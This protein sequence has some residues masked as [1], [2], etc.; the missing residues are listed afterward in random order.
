MKKLLFILIFILAIASISFGQSNPPLTI[1]EVD[2]SPKRTNAS[3]LIFPNGTVS[4]NGSRV[5]IDLSSLGGGTVTNT[6]SL[7]AGKV[8]IG[9]GLGDLKASKV[10]ITDPATTATLT[11][12][13]NKVFTVSNTLTLAGTDS[14]TLNVGAGGTLGTAAFTAATAYEVP[15][16][17]STGLGRS[18]NTITVNTTLNILKISG[19]TTNGFV[20]TSGGDGTLSV[21]TS[22]YITATSTDTL[23]NKT[24]AN[25]NNSL[26]SVTVDVTGT[27]ATGDIYYRNAGGVLTRLG[28]GS[29]GQVL[30]L[31]SGLPSWAA[32]GGG[33]GGT[34]AGSGSEIQFRSDASTFG[35]VT[36]SSV[37]GATMTLAGILT[38]GIADTGTNTVA[39]P[40]VI[41]HTSS[42]TTL[43][44]FGVGITY[45]LEG[46]G[47]DNLP[48]GSTAFVFSDPTDAS[49]DADFVIRAVANSVIAEK[50]RFTSA[51]VL[52]I[53]GTSPTITTLT[54]NASLT[55]DANG[56]GNVVI[57]GDR[58][59]FP[60]AGPGGSINSFGF[61]SN[62][63]S[64][65]WN[66]GGEMV[67]Y[68]GGEVGGIYSGGIEL[69]P[70][71]V[72]AWNDSGIST[73]R[74]LGI[75]KNATGIVEINNATL[76]TFRDL[77]LRQLYADA[78][79]TAGGTTGN[80]TID[81]SAGSVNF[82][83][84]ATT[85]TVTDSLVSTSSIIICTVL[86]NDG[87][88]AIKNVVPGAGSFV[89]TL[90]AAATAETRVGFV[91]INK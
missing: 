39:Y 37:S 57:T 74:G 88:A 2:G 22:T 68:I 43:A 11:I 28:V 6:G 69:D 34:P 65:F 73:A 42:N 84:A 26:G 20:K 55:L 62:P 27:D 29:D 40:L 78:T 41:N 72:F 9:N 32:A 77:K 14:S 1:R 63:T 19:L 24:F 71:K 53:T 8:I 85:L 45:S 87:T 58:L 16:T 36:G 10:T 61:A 13:N 81:K 47:D 5:T 44:S 7:T 90:T 30:T 82:A 56:T 25:S 35:A 15:L 54:T 64:G 52:S 79:L 50:F 75:G 91:V 60:D 67:I 12:I 4:V 17:F 21:D 49:I 66:F 46:N 48:V 59:I 31:A 70:L 89:I 76:G 80:Q 38:L 51:S 23:Q 33:G 86:T 3:D 83:A 18:T